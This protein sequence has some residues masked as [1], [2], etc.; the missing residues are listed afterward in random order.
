M[1]W[2]YANIWDSLLHYMYYIYIQTL[3]HTYIPENLHAHKTRLFDTTRKSCK[4]NLFEYAYA[5]RRFAILITNMILRVL[6][7]IVCSTYYNKVEYE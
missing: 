4:L 7:E 2:E 5:L 6:V 3:V 1:T